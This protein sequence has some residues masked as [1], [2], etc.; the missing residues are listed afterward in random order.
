[1]L[2][3]AALGVDDGLDAFRPL[4]AGLER[5]PANLA[6]G[7]VYQFDPG[8]GRGARFIGGSEISGFDAGH[9]SLSWWLVAADS[10]TGASVLV[11]SRGGTALQRGLTREGTGGDATG[12]VWL[13][14]WLWPA[15]RL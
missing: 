4:P 6:S 2:D 1:M 13:S 5:V 15:R 14:S 7:K 12:R 9:V 8:F 10:S 11:V 3:L